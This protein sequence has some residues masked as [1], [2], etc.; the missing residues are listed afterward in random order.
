LTTGEG[1][2]RERSDM[3]RT[4]DLEVG[5]DEKEPLPPGGLWEKESRGK[6]EITHIIASFVT[7]V[8]RISPYK[9]ADGL[10]EEHRI[11]ESSF[12]LSQCGKTPAYFILRTT[13]ELGVCSTGF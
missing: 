9:W 2:K 10:S 6:C 5:Q 11:H 1:G 13:N 3:L 4:G 8:K 7:E 12:N